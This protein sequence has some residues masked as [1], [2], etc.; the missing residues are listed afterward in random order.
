[1]LNKRED[2]INCSWY[3]WDL[4]SNLIVVHNTLFTM[5]Y[6]DHKNVD[7]VIGVVEWYWYVVEKQLLLNWEKCHF[8]VKQC[9]VLG[10]IVSF[11][12]IEVDKVVIE[13]IFKLLVPKTVKDIISF[14]RICWTISFYRRFIKNFTSFLNHCVKY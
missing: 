5:I 9:I 7:D 4:A 14:F 13:L 1:M 8:L 3:W 11:R 10:R 6:L 2:I 12:G